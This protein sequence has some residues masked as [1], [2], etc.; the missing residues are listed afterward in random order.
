MSIPV[1]AFCGICGAFLLLALGL[2]KV[3]FELLIIGAF[4]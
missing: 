3:G 1:F 2:L 4:C